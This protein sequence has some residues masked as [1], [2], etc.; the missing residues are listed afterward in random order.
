[1]RVVFGLKKKVD[2]SVD[3][4]ADKLCLGRPLDENHQCTLL[5]L[6]MSVISMCTGL[7]QKSN[8]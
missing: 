1:M 5:V 4:H 8:R 2:Q 3:A 6:E 7:V